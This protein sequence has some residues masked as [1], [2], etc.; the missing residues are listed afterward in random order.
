MMHCDQ[1]SERLQ[2][3][4][5]SKGRAHHLSP[6]LHVVNVNNVLLAEPSCLDGP[7]SRLALSRCTSERNVTRIP[8]EPSAA[9]PAPRGG[10][11]A[12]SAAPSGGS[13]RAAGPEGNRDTSQPGAAERGGGVKALFARGSQGSSRVQIQVQV[14]LLCPKNNTGRGK[15]SC[16]N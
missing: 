10:V 12:E 5:I 9:A 7:S 13:G 8:N 11:T 3:M 14:W 2:S 6:Y 4:H 16:T 1:Q 15:R